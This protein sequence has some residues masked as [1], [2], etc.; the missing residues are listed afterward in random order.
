[1]ILDEKEI[2]HLGASLIKNLNKKRQTPNFKINL[3]WGLSS[4]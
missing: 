4:I 3:K 1:M 2:Y